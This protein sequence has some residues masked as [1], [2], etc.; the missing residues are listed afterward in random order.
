MRVR[1]ASSPTQIE[2]PAERIGLWTQI[3]E[4]WATNGRDWTRPGFRALA[5]HRLG[6]WRMGVKP[7]LLRVPLSVIYRMLYRFVRNHYGIELYYTV[8]V[9]RRVLIGH[10]GAIVIHPHAEI[11]DD[12]V[13]RQS[14]TLGASSHW[15]AYEAPKI[16]KGVHMGAGAMVLGNVTV[17]DG[18]SIG[19]NVVVTKDVP[20]HS[21]IRP[22]PYQ[23]ILPESDAKEVAETS[24]SNR[25]RGLHLSAAFVLLDQWVRGVGALASELAPAV[26]CC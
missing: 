7:R 2:A 5:V 13:L 26:I 23:V 15:R 22:A 21:K 12:C 24:G 9:G 14:I 11:G 3:R 1:I 10:Q 19:A 6:V 20:A 17:G 8:K 18:A 4:D 16:G 25:L